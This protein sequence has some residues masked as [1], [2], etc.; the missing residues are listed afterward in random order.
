MA[1]EKSPE[2]KATPTKADQHAAVKRIADR[3]EKQD[4]QKFSGAKARLPKARM[5]DATALEAKDPEHHYLYVNA[6]DPGNLQNHVDDGYEAVS[7]DTC[8]GAGV[9]QRVS[10]LVLM[11]IPREVYEER[12]AEQKE[13][14]NRRLEAHKAEFRGEVEGIVR[15]LRDRGYKDHDIRRMLV[16]E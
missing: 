1:T 4:S 2:P 11:K 10:E 6:D 9:R 16:D 3:L 12:V 8:K 7:E 15:E 5:L 14:A 13:V